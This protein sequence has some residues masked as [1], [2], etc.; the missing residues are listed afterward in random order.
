MQLN[1]THEGLVC[2]LFSSI[3]IVHGS[4]GTHARTLVLAPI[5]HETCSGHNIISRSVFPT[6]YR[7]YIIP[8][9]P[10]LR[11]AGVSE[12]PLQLTGFVK[13]LVRLRNTL[14][15]K[16]F[17]H[18]GVFGS[19]TYSEYCLRRRPYP[20]SPGPGPETRV[21]E[22]RNRLCCSD[23]AQRNP[24]HR[25]GHQQPEPPKSCAPNSLDGMGVSPLRLTKLIRVPVLTQ[26]TERVRCNAI[27]LSSLDPRSPI[28][29]QYGTREMN[30]VAELDPREE[31]DLMEAK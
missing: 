2:L 31:V 10:L 15:S 17:R 22:S 13:I 1:V 29:A 19:T 6:D 20:R 14:F 11:L 21:H 7:N 26:M 8:E 12:E 30:G 24:N 25:T 28:A 5:A 4:Y 9:A 18:H 27:G 23:I 3:C 16:T